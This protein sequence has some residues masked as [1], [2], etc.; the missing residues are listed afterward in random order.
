MNHLKKIVWLFLY[1]INGVLP[2]KSGK[3]LFHSTPSF[4]DNSKTLWEYISETLEY[5]TAWIVDDKKSYNKMKEAGIPVFLNNTF[6]GIWTIFRSK[7]LV[8]TH[9]A[10]FKVKA[11]NQILINLW[12]GSPLKCMGFLDKSENKET[13]INLI[14]MSK[15]IDFLITTSSIMKYVLI[16]SFCIFPSKV[17]ILGQP[18]NDKLFI[19]STKT[20]LFEDILQITK[21]NFS[22]VILY[23]P[24][25]RE[26]YGQRVE[27]EKIDV[28]KRNY[29]RLREFE[30]VKLEEFL[31][32]NNYLL[33]VKLHQNEETY[34]RESIKN[35]ISSHIKFL[36]TNDLESNMCFLY[37]FLNLFDILVTDYSSIFYDYLLMDRP[38]IFIENDIDE[39]RNIRGLL[40]DNP[41][42]WMPGYKVKTL[43]GF[44]NAVLE[45][46]FEDKY[47]ENRKI[48]NE[49]ANLYKDGQSCKRISSL[50]K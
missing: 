25:F 19:P 5:E 17:L 49:L 14:N 2:K 6:Q 26:G 13:M 27:G 7:Y 44:Q 1:W 24:T 48:I 38:I 8:T 28:D 31:R 11:S 20:D 46:S 15:K 9:V 37:D 10:F 39:Y 41:H 33:V 34:Y 35:N 4:S 12:H 32:E 50:F 21:A 40:F 22:K 43:Q 42:F 23:A 45:C 18:R 36:W 47:V 30:F 16:S 3:I 29:M